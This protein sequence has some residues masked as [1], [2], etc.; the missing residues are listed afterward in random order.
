MSRMRELLDVQKVLV[1]AL[2]A[3][4]LSLEE[5]DRF[6][7]EEHKRNGHGAHKRVSAAVLAN[8][9]KALARARGQA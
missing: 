5:Y 6:V 9:K 2:D 4:L 1:S 7:A 8:A 3:A